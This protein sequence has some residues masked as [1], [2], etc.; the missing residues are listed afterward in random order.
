MRI[1][2]GAGE[3]PDPSYDIHSD[4]LPLPHIELVCPM[5]KI[6]VAAGEFDGLRA[7]DVLE[8]QSWELVVPT[9]KEWARI[10]VPGSA[11][12]IQVPN[13][14]V[15][16]TRWVA[17]TITTR[18]F[19]Y[20]L[21]G[22]HSERLAHQGVDDRGVPKWIWNAHHAAFDEAWLRE[23]L[24]LAGFVDISIQSDGGTNLV[25]LCKRGEQ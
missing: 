20:W 4:I 19:N 13:A 24:T 7:S 10:L 1:E 22:G 2:I 5:D 12:Y 11:C 23:L 21:L 9:L 16:A 18:D 3:N 14:W 15:L 17:G 8:H 6:P 25:C